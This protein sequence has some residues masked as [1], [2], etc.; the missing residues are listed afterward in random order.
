MAKNLPQ[1]KVSWKLSRSN[2]LQESLPSSWY[3]DEAVYRLE[4]ETIFAREWLCVAREEQVPG[5]AD[6]LVLDVMGE[7]ERR[8]AYGKDVVF[9]ALREFGFDFMRDNLKLSSSE[10]VQK[11]LDV[12]IVDEA[13]HAMIDE[14]NIPLIISGGYGG[15]PRITTKLR[16][17]IE[18][19][20][21]QQCAVDFFVATLYLFA[22]PVAKV[23]PQQK[24]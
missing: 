14:A 5:I 18:H 3:L 16:T 11:K 23:R 10:T 8:F 17:A 19:L 4:K 15:T 6:S 20:I 2:V 21:D 24:Y 9:G 12:A 7:S 13:D 22:A 1:T